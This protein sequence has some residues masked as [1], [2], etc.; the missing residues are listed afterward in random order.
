MDTY[1]ELEVPPEPPEPTGAE[2]EVDIGTA[3]AD[4]D[5]SALRLLISGSAV[6]QRMVQIG[7]SQRGV[8]ESGGPNRGIP[9]ERYCKPF[10]YRDPIP[11]CACFV[12]WCYWQTTGARPPWSQPAYVG[13]V[14]NWAASHRALV[15]NPSFGDMFGQGDDHMG[16]VV[17]RKRSG[18]F[19][20]I[21]GNWAD[22]VLS[23][24][25]PIDGFWFATP[26][27]G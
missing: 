17:A 26:R 27:Y 16:M 14:Y 4:E 24:E 3:L 21:E 1:P 8:A 22:R 12:S 7:L 2:V 20:T 23:Q 11:W 25:R 6:G 15:T 5:A 10:G 19:V 13:S 9:F 18:V